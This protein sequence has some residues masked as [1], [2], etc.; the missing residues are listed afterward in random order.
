MSAYPPCNI[1][2]RKDNQDFPF[3]KEKNPK[4]VKCGI[5]LNFLR[6]ASSLAPFLAFGSISR[7]LISQEE[8]KVG[9]FRFSDVAQNAIMG[10]IDWK[11]LEIPKE[12]ERGSP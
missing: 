9:G 4:I 12:G 11:L 8:D 10:E 2:F 6:G 7:L 1:E 5:W 3:I